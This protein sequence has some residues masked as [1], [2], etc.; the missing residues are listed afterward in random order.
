VGGYDDGEGGEGSST[1][2]IHIQPTLTDLTLST[3]HTEHLLKLQNNLEFAFR[4]LSHY[5]E[6]LHYT[7]FV[8]RPI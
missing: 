5:L 8:H 7:D 3:P 4:I 2:A 6:R 1:F